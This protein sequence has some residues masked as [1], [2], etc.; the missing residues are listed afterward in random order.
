MRKIP[1]LFVRD[2]KTRKV[3]PRLTP[4]CEWVLRGEGVPTE[5]LD[6]TNVRLTVRSGVVVRVEKRRNPSK[7]Q[8]SAGILTPWY[9]DA[10]H[11]DPSNK[12]IHAAVVG[13]HVRDW[14]DGE[15]PCEA[16]GPKIQGNPLCLEAPT[17]WPFL[18]YPP[19]L[20]L[21]NPAWDSVEDA[22][23]VLRDVT[24]VLASELVGAAPDMAAEGIVWHHPDG[25]MAKLKRKDFAR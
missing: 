12:H 11:D 18:L 17:C 19:A 10:P 20:T 5:K 3:V 9:V 2:D 8:K 7:A 21:I 13:T 14:P 25:R 1:T 15:H 22:F 16:L 23:A 24:R 6:G 4:G